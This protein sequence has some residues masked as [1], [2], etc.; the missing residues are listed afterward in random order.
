MNVFDWPTI[1]KLMAS[2]KTRDLTIRHA[3]NQWVEGNSV[4]EDMNSSEIAH[5]FDV[6]RAGWLICEDFTH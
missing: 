5:M 2:Q 3:F 1:R 4:F 6:F